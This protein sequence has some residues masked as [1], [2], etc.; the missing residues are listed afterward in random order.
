MG[1][2]FKQPNGPIPPVADR[3][4]TQRAM[5][6]DRWEDDYFWLREKSDPGVA[7]YLEAE[8]TYA[9]A[10]LER[11]QPLANVLYAEM[12]GRIKQT[13][14]SVPYGLG[15]FAYYT[16]TVEGQQYP[17]YCRKRGSEEGPEEI[18]LDLNAMAQGLSFMALG[19]LQVS[20]DGNLLAYSTDSTGFRV[21]TLWVKD[22]RTGELLPERVPGVGSAAWSSDDRTLFYTT[23]DEAKRQYRLYRHKLGAA[24]PD[25]LV[26]EEADELFHVHVGETRSKRFLVLSV[27]S[28]TTSEIRF[29]PADRPEE[30]W[31]LVAPRIHEQE[32][33]LDHRGAQFLI[34]TND[35]GRNF[36]LVTVPIASSGR[37]H[38]S[39][40]VPHRA[41][42]MLEGFDV[43]ERYLVRYEREDGVPA[44]RV[45]DWS[46]GETHSVEF[47][48]PVFEV[49][50][51]QNRNWDTSFVRYHYESL[52][53]PASVFDYDLS[54]RTRT[55]RKQTE[56][57][58]GYD[59]SQYR[60][61][62]IH[63]QAPD[64]T[65]VPISLVYRRGLI[66][67]GRSPVL[68]EGYG[69]Y[70]IPFPTTFS[71]NRLSLLDRGVV[72]AIAHV[73]GGGDLGKPWHDAGRMRQKM[74]TFTD[75]I[76]S[77]DHLVAAAY[78]RADRI[79]IEGGSAGGLLMGAVV[80]LR[81]ERVK[82]VLSVVPF[83]DVI[84]SMSDPSLPLTVGEYEEW[85][86]PADL[87]D[88]AYMRQYCPYSN[89]QRGRYPAMLVRTSLNDSQ[90]MYWE[91]AK[92]VA[93]LRTLKTDANPLLLLTNMGAGHG[94]SSGRY[95]RLRELALDYA[96][97]LTQVGAE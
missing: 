73:R 17:L 19:L 61:E 42:I 48:E 82:A 57:V 94:G 13:D 45:T 75:F 6:G 93:K 23:E 28:H 21:Y 96:F 22:L 11:V 69:A 91:P 56:V 5:H 9:G 14:L 20:H 36:R 90:V 78:T 3:R 89:L 2:S 46:T 31:T 34:R 72:Y 52:V 4:P 88:Y 62:R 84:N 87:D 15:D 40:V 1:G 60:S 33:D 74:N 80:N 27:G 38:W 16:R 77:I 92:Y 35:S 41:A 70:G 37:L 81:P 86:N 54:T 76:A 53:T 85:G 51:G 8:N 55:L 12:L 47:P 65:S 10:V 43:F 63:A 50:P 24:G 18:M 97:I 25:D 59:A 26:Y 29:L 30:H 7:A 32:Y 95:D 68:L 49:S 83:V 71:S 67:D 39:E 44:I 79:V 66:R 64:G 58:G